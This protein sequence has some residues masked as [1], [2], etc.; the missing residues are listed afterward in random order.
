MPTIIEKVGFD[1]ME[2]LIAV[3][4]KPEN[5]FPS[6]ELL[7]TLVWD[8]ED[9]IPGMLEAYGMRATN[10]NIRAARLA[11]HRQFKILFAS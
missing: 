4:A 6:A 5:W 11:F 1:C 10:G 2:E 9:K 3:R 7:Q 8:I